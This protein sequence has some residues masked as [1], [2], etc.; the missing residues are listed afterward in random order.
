MQELYY[1]KSWFVSKAGISSNHFDKMTRERME[2]G[3]NGEGYP[4]FAISGF[5]YRKYQA[6]SGT[7]SATTTDINQEEEDINIKTKYENLVSKRLKNRITAMI[8]VRKTEAEARM[9]ELLSAASVSV[10]TSIQVSAEKCYREQVTMIM[11]VLGNDEAGKARFQ[12]VKKHL[13]TT[14]QYVN[15]LTR[16]YRDSVDRLKA[17]SIDITWQDDGDVQALQKQMKDPN[18]KGAD[19]EMDGI[20]EELDD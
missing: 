17:G 15:L 9:I 7:R 2:L 16:E 19:S 8:Y 20:M 4:L 3:D 5:W 12:E 6:V 13:I 1:P 11:K 14:R 18:Q 10:Q